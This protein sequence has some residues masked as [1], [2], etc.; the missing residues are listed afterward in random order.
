MAGPLKT[1]RLQTRFLIAGILLAATTV[2]SGIVSAL[3]FSRLSRGI[4]ETL[5]G[6]QDAIDNAATLSGALEREDDA[7]L[8]AMSG[9]PARARQELAAQRQIFDRSYASLLGVL[10]QED[11]KAAA[12][13][14]KAHVET[15]RTAGDAFLPTAQDPRAQE[16]YR[17]YLNPVLREAVADCGRIRDINFRAM[18]AG[19]LEA[20]ELATRST[21]FIVLVALVALTVSVIVSFYLARSVERPIRELT[22]SVD[23]LRQGD[24]TRRVPAGAPDEIGILSD[25]FN[26]MAEALAEFRRVNL[27]EVLQAKSTLESTLSALPDAVLVVR[28][29]GLIETMNARARAVLEGLGKAG[30]RSLDDLGLPL[31]G[32]VAVSRALLGERG[33]ELRAE[34]G[35]AISVEMEGR[36]RKLLP[37]AVPIL[38]DSSDRPG[39]ILVL[40]D[41]SE[42][43]RLDELRTELIGATSH[44]LKTPLTTLRMN[45]LLLGEDGRGLSPRQREIVSAAVSGCED[46]ARTVDEL[47]DLTRIEAGQLKLHL[48]RVAIGPLLENAVSA[49][50]PRF[51]DAG[52]DLGVEIAGGREA[53]LRGD[54]ARLRVVFSNLLG[55]A[56]KYTPKGGNVSVSMSSRQNEGIP[57]S[58]TLQIAVTDSGPGVPEEFRSRVFEKFFRIEHERKFSPGGPKGAG[59]GLYLS[60][61]IVEAHGGRIRCEAGP[62]G[63]GARLA[64]ELPADLGG[65]VPQPVA[66]GA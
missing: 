46:L 7:L 58:A 12:K 32:T 47:L 49:L 21:S 33:G 44:E 8:M 59:I 5:Q 36:P 20:R 61:Q 45:L 63:R 2:A 3:T 19:G 38:K 62:G 4:G 11:E 64:L 15:Y 54:P 53:T 39:A 24:F 40:Y 17:S 23:A 26:R 27:A 22:A 9:D 48:E 66:T 43:A 51:E 13:S 18:K 28:A 57:G 34:L 6:S 56:L 30:A 37:I 14:L 31:S 55:N 60:R 35:N 25:G 42:F 65:N 50:R 29:G 52:I 41:V 10:T 16:R 1:R